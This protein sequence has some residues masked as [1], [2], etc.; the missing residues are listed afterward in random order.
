MPLL[1]SAAFGDDLVYQIANIIGDE[2]RAFVN[3]GVT[4]MDY[5]A[6]HINTCEY[7][8]WG[9][10][11]ETP[12]SDI[13]GIK[14]Y[15]KSLLAG[16]EGGQAQRKIIATCKHYIPMQD[17]AEYYMPPFQQCA[18]ASKVRSFVCSYNAVNGVPTCADTYV[19]QTI[20]CYHWNWTESNNYITSDC[21]AVADVSENHNYTNTLAEYTAVAFSA[22]MDN[23]CEYKGSSDIPILQNSSVPDNWTTNAL[24]AAQ[25][26]DHIISF[27]GL[28]TPAAAEGFDRTDISWP[29]TQVELITKLAQLGK[30]LIVVVLG[31][32][33]DNSPLL[34]MEGVKSVIWTNWSGQDGGSAVMQVISAV[35]A[36]AGRLPIMQYPASYTN[37]SMLDM[38]LRPDASSPGWTYRWCNR[39]VQPFDLGSH[40][41]TFAANFGSSEGLTYNIQETIRNCAQKY[42][43]LFGVP[44]LEVAVMN[45]GN[46]ALDF[47]TLAFIKD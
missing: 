15:T 12:G 46:R 7:P 4:P 11:S 17:L 47:V 5:W 23:S 13:L 39:S 18:Q 3:D 26:S 8:R 45:E 33:V 40:Y 29:G 19:L 37:L 43:C 32:M 41:I 38:N 24:H 20:L 1:M 36:V 6:P 9:R 14:S 35:H 27:G 2:A 22:G 25:G 30:P 34:S 16:L 10:G 28:D 21:E 31:D 42:S 44:P